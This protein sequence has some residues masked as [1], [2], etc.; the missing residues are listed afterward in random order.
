[1]NFLI[2]SRTPTT[3]FLKDIQTLKKRGLDLRKL[4][5]IINLLCE[6]KEL[7]KRCRPH[8]L[9]GDLSGFWEC[10]IAADWLLIYQSTDLSVT[11]IRTGTHSDLF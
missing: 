11:L 1:M 6:G 8:R 10:H 7:P 2:R 4:E 5:G 9:S 3:R